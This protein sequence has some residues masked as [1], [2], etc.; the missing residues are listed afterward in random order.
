MGDGHKGIV[1]AGHWEAENVDTE[2][3]EGGERCDEGG[4]AQNGRRVRGHAEG[5]E[6]CV[7]MGD[8]RRER[9]KE[10]NFHI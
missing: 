5:S 1:C 2:S 8:V 10:C 9:L 4:N 3:G 6:P 7:M